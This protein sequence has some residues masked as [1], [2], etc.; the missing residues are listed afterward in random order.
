M[1]QTMIDKSK[2]AEDWFQE[3][4]ALNKQ[5][6]YE[7]AVISFSNAIAIDP[8]LS[9]AYSIRADIFRFQRKFSEALSDCLIACELTPNDHWAFVVCADVHYYLEQFDQCVEAA[10]KA[11]ELK[12]RA[13]CY[14]VRAKGYHKLQQYHKALEDSNA[15][16]DLDETENEALRSRA[17]ALRDLGEYSQAID[18]FA[19]FIE[20]FPGHEAVPWALAEKA[21]C[22]LRINENSKALEEAE[23]AILLD[24]EDSSGLRRRARAHQKLGHHKSAIEDFSSFLEN[25]PEHG[26]RAWAYAARSHSLLELDDCSM[27]IS[28]ASACL[29]LE[30]TGTTAAWALRIR[31][32]AR[33]RLGDFAQALIDSNRAID[34]GGE[35][36][37]WAYVTR[38][39][40]Y[41]ET[42]RLEE[43]LN[44]FNKVM[45]LEPTGNTT[46]KYGRARCLG[47]M[48]MQEIFRAA[49]AKD[50]HDQD[51]LPS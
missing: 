24:P 11:I 22:Y 43:A 8:L 19:S 48:K 51:S 28:D 29:E 25:F 50:T 14:A 36:L 15:A 42:N 20:E 38:A 47:Q 44:D 17:R 21:Y 9:R 30:S 23:K 34:E 37:F 33:R 13:R 16:L 26:E 12:Q 45:Q 31:S 41:E 40:I 35:E 18:S 10:T 1:Y 32:I 3:G 5:G 6:D 39:M 7:Q 49:S 27:A 2:S 4:R 46:G